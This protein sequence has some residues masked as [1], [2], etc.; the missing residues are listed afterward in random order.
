MPN[1]LANPLLQQ[2]EDKIESGLTPENRANYMK[3][4]VAGLHIA[5][6]NGPSGFMAKL[7]KSADPIADAAK[8]A[9]SLVIIMRH[10][11]RGIMPI[12][13]MIPAALTLML[14]ALDFVDRSKIAPVGQPDLVRATHIFTDFLFARFGISKAGLQN[15]MQRVHAITQDPQAMAKINLKAGFTRHPDAATPTPLPAGPAGMINT[16]GA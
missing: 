5:L 9:V 4:V 15:A 12:K 1:Q 8:G 7:A 16:N 10:Q 11:A 6:A 13:A 2:V 14:R 3:V